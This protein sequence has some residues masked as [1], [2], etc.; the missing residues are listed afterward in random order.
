MY[1]PRKRSLEIFNAASAPIRLKILRL[2]YSVGPLNYSEIMNQ[3]ELS[4]NRDAG[5][6]AYH[7]KSTVNAG[8]VNFVKET[9]KYKISSIGRSVIDFDQRIDEY[10]QRA[11]GKLLVRT[12]R[13]AIEEFDKNMFVRFLLWINK[14]R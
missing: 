7:L 8:L 5:K 3:L 14:G 6:F 9:K 12:S 13:I 11:Q 1:N 10:L 4:P 2:L